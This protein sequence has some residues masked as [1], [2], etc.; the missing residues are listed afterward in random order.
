[1]NYNGTVNIDSENKYYKVEDNILY[2]K[3]GN[4]EPSTL[5]SVLY[6]IN[7]T[8]QIPSTVKELEYDSFYGQRKMT[9]ITIP[10][11]VE[12]IR[13]RA[14]HYCSILQKVEIPSTIKTIGSCFGDATNNLEEII[15]HKAEDEVTGAPWGAVKGMK[16]VKWVGDL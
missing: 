2:K 5:V 3:D 14:F 13:S 7:G 10:E 8:I 16:V 1:M 11:G 4:G 9:E 12:T 15:V 6:Q